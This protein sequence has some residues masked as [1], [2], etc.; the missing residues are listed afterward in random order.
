MFST[1]Q[2]ELTLSNERTAAEYRIISYQMTDKSENS[3]LE[4]IKTYRKGHTSVKQLYQW[5]VPILNDCYRFYNKEKGIRVFYSC[6][7]VHDQRH[8]QIYHHLLFT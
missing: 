3:N 6:I 1:C 8:H 7:D 2:T 4:V 5:N